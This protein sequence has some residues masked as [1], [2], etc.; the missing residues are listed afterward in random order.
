[1]YKHILVAVNESAAAKK[2]L[3]EAIK[4]A[5]GQNAQVRLINVVDQSLGS[6]GEHG[7]LSN[8]KT[9]A[10][11]N[12]IQEAAVKILEEAAQFCREAGV[13]AQTAMPKT[14]DTAVADKILEEA[15]HWPADL[16]VM[17]THG[18]SGVQRLLLGSVATAVVQG[19]RTPVMLVRAQ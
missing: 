7:W 8:A 18:R 17:G 15:E 3:A 14:V 4:L 5:S 1:M 11:L 12:S 6:Y 13:E 16:I 10:D 19:T 9:N 2:A